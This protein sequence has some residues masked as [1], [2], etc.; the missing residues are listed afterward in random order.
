MG[1]LSHLPVLL[2]RS[3]EIRDLPG[4]SDS[5][6]PESVLHTHLTLDSLWPEIDMKTFSTNS[7]FGLARLLALLVKQ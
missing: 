1:E 3:R 6:I 7:L 2:E 4:C 5:L